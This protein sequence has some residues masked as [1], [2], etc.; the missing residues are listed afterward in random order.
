[1]SGRLARATPASERRAFK[2]NNEGRMETEWSLISQ[3]ASLYS[4]YLVGLATSG[5]L[6]TNR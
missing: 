2:L 4:E 6:L 5:R 1:M 3:D